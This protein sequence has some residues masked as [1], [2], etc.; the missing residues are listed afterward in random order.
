LLLFFRKEDP[1]LLAG[2]QKK[3]E[4]GTLA[5]CVSAVAPGVAAYSSSLDQ[6]G[7]MFF[8]GKKNQK[9][10][11]CLGRACPG[12]AEPGSLEFFASFFFKKEGLPSSPP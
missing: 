12:N 9:T 8:F 7:R 5:A 4:L 11:D 2:T 10:F 1:S 3:P 6:A